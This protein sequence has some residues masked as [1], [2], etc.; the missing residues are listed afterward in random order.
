MLQRKRREAIRNRIS[1][2]R[3]IK[4]E[5]SENDFVQYESF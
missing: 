4:K 3:K 5:R 1:Q 2:R